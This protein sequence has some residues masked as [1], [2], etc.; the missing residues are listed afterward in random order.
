[1]DWQPIETAPNGETILVAYENGDL[2]LVQHYDNDY[3]WVAFKG[4]AR[5]GVNRPFAWT[6]PAFPEAVPVA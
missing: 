4:E 3:E 2:R 6:K 5:F 1:M